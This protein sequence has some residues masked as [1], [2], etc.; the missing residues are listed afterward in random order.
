MNSPRKINAWLLCNSENSYYTGH[1]IT[2]GDRRTLTAGSNSLRNKQV[3]CAQASAETFT[4]TC[5]CLTTVYLES[6]NE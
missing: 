5:C 2:N 6:F 3:K 4:V 1:I